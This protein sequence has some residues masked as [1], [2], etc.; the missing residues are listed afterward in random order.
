MSSS[1][2]NDLGPFRLDYLSWYQHFSDNLDPTFVPFKYG[3]VMLVSLWLWFLVHL[4]ATTSSDYFSPTL[5]S[6][7]LKGKIGSNLAGVT[8]LA[9]ANGAPDVFSSISGI[10]RTNS[11]DISIGELFGGALFISTMVISAVAILSPT[12][13]QLS[14]LDFTRDILFL[15]LAVTALAYAGFFLHAMTLVT[16]GGFLCMYLVYIG[17]VLLSPW[18]LHRCGGGGSSSRNST[19]ESKSNDLPH[20]LQERLQTAFWFKGRK[21]RMI[22]LFKS[23]LTTENPQSIS[24]STLSYHLNLNLLFHPCKGIKITSLRPSMVI[25]CIAQVLLPRGTVPYKE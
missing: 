14:P 23:F 13:I 16:A 17:S 5:A 18:W 6:I 19:D 20:P 24:T 15:I 10:L 1:T 25:P 21:S 12:H 22:E 9:F 3:I 2:S 7:S 11:A 8:L 4:L